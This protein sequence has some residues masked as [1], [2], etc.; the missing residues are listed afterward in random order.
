MWEGNGVGEGKDL[1]VV[2]AQDSFE[3][4]PDGLVVIEDEDPDWGGPEG[5]DASLRGLLDLGLFLPVS[6]KE[7]L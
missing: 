3:Y 1:A 6:I 7:G 2:S 4:V 5:I